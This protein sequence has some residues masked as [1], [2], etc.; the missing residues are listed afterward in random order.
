VPDACEQLGIGDSRFHALRGQWL[1]AALQLLEPRPLGRPP[2]AVDAAPWQARLQALEAENRT[3]RQQLAA[4]EVRRELAEIL[5]HVVHTP[6]EVVKKG[7]PAA[8]RR[9][10]RRLR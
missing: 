5:P 10:R 6:D 3:L 9:K 7:A 8:P 1:Q 4:A 2:Q